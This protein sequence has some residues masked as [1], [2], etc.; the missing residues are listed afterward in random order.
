MAVDRSLLDPALN[1]RLDRL[2]EQLAAEGLAIRFVSGRRTCAEQNRLYAQGRTT[3]G[4]I[5]THARSR[6]ERTTALTIS[7]LFAPS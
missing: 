3:A 6:C 5:V 2:T 4:Q 1:E 7:W